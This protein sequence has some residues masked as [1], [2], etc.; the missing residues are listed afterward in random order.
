MEREILITDLT[1]MGGD[2]V[3]IAGVDNAGQTVRPVLWNGVRY[4]HLLRDGKALI[5]PRAVLRMRLAP[6]RAAAPHME[7]HDWHTARVAPFD[8]VFAGRGALAT[9]VA[10]PGRTTARVRCSALNCWK[11]QKP[12]DA[13]CISGNPAKDATYSL[14]TV[15]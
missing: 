4:S 10:G 15:R 14:A 3:C 11:P 7:D 13:S 8:G 9:R 2:R 6:K 5:R 12:G 1:A